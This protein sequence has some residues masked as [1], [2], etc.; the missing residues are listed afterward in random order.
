MNRNMTERKAF[1]HALMTVGLAVLLVTSVL[2]FLAELYSRTRPA[3][4]E[5]W[6]VLAGI[7]LVT[8]LMM[9]PFVYRRYL[10]GPPPPLSP[11]QHRIQAMWQTAY[12]I[13]YLAICMLSGEKRISKWEWMIVGLLLSSVLHHLRLAYKKEGDTSLAQ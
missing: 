1:W 3:F 8:G 13:A 12:V 11:R 5:M 9:L 4:A 6:P 2:L 7:F 10:A